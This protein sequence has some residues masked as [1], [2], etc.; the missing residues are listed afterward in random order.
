[1]DAEKYLEHLSLITGRQEDDIRKIYTSSKLPSV[2]VFNYQDWP[3]PGLITRFTLVFRLLTMKTG[4]L[5]NQN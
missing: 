5:A 4:D 1:M 3:E 2:F